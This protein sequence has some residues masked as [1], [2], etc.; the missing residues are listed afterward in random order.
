[1]IEALIIAGVFALGTLL[2]GW[3]VAVAVCVLSVVGM[4]LLAEK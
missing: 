4:F 3:M 2:F 1:M